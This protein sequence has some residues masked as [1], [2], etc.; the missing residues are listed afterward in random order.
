MDSYHHTT[1]TAHCADSDASAA[2]IHRSKLPLEGV[3][4][5]GFEQ[6]LDSFRGLGHKTIK[7]LTFR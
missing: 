5:T 2:P 1:R 4:V 7:F 6:A 3:M